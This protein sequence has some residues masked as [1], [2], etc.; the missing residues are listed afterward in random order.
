MFRKVSLLAR[1]DF[2]KIYYDSSTLRLSFHRNSSPN[3]SS[4]FSLFFI[5]YIMTSYRMS[6]FSF[7]CVSIQFR[8]YKKMIFIS[9]GCHVSINILMR[10]L[11]TTAW[12]ARV[13]T[14]LKNSEKN[15]N[16]NRWTARADSAFSFWLIIMRA[17]R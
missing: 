5:K 7:C 11:W 6:F 15:Q 12:N 3:F 17:F 1:N 2:S 13:R 4:S 10:F 14:M 16:L 9:G 8:V